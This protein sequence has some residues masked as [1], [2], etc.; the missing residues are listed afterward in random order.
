[1]G[2]ACTRRHAT[3]AENAMNHAM[4]SP[5]SPENMLGRE[6]ATS[7][8]EPVEVVIGRCMRSTKCTMG[9]TG[10]T[11]DLAYSDQIALSM[12]LRVRHA[13]VR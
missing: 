1:M 10:Q 6:E 11:I 2:A 12:R 9:P 13:G 8:E 7:E 5:R 3:N 4:K